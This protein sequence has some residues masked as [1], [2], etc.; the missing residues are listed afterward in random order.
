MN[1]IRTYRYALQTN[2]HVKEIYHLV[3]RLRSFLSLGHSVTWSLD[4]SV[5]RSL[6][7]T[8][9]LGHLVTRPLGHLVTGSLGHSVTWSLGH[10]V[11]WSL[12]H[13]VTHSLG[14]YVILSFCFNNAT[15]LT[16]N[17]RTSRSA[18]QT[19]KTLTLVNTKLKI[20][21]AGEKIDIYLH[22]L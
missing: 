17:I 9:P 16:D 20:G 21:S 4:H 1:K 11:T 15:Q 8:R 5:T 22:K 18:S 12:S 2:K 13:S 7:V 19:T 10:L 3:N 14:H 6:S